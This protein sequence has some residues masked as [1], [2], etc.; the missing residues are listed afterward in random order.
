MTNLYT[1][2]QDFNFLHMLKI[3]RNHYSKTFIVLLAIVDCVLLVVSFKVAFWSEF[4]STFIPAGHYQAF[5]AVC[6]L[7]WVIASLMRGAYQPD[8]LKSFSRISKTIFNSFPFYALILAAYFIFF[9]VYKVPDNFIISAHSF[10]VLLSIG[11][12]YI[13]LV[14]YS[15]IRNREENRSRTIIVGYTNAGRELYRFFKKSK[16]SGFEFLGFF[17]DKH[18][19]KLI[20][21][22]LDEIKDF[23]IRNNVKEIYYALPNNK[24]L[25][26]ELT[27]FADN[28]FIHFG[29]VQD[30]TG[31]SYDRLHTYNYGN[32]IPVLS[33]TKAHM[34]KFD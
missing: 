10:F 1:L 26:K 30:L 21:G 6:L 22:K 2:F 13:M 8:K 12:K 4:N 15:L 11:T 14:I 23:C 33:Y 19:N 9:N 29:L 24:Q 20:T 17:D 16:R 3:K 31:L 32:E 7:S 28:N 18:Q 25:V 34:G 27:H 5:L